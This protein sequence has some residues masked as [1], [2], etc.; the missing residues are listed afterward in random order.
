M[1]NAEGESMSLM[2]EIEAKLR[3]AI[4]ARDAKAASCLRMLKSRIIEKRTSASFKGELTDQVIQDVATTYVKQLTKS[5]GEFEKG[6]ES[7]R[8]MI[9]QTKWEID[10]LSEFL[11]KHLDEAATQAIVEGALEESGITDPAQAGR[12]I[13]IVMK[14]HKGEVDA[15]LVRRLIEEKLSPSE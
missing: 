14:D 1:E 5:I 7:A 8:E 3:A 15:V 2:E 4:K 11:P 13:G 10:Y 12:V 9:T 6:G